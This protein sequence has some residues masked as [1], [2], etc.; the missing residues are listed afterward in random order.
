MFLLG[1]DRHCEERER[2]R[3]QSIVPTPRYGLLARNDG[4]PFGRTASIRPNLF[5]SATAMRSRLK[6][7][8]DSGTKR[9]RI[10]DSPRDPLRSPQHLALTASGDTRSSLQGLD[11][12]SCQGGILKKRENAESN[13]K[14]SGV[15][16]DSRWLYLISPL[17]RYLPL[18]LWER[19][20]RM[21][22]AHSRRARG[23]LHKH[24]PRGDR[25]LIRRGLRSRHLL[26]QGEKEE[27]APCFS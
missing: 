4:S 25:P 6:L 24:R 2:R 17:A 13:Q 5:Q 10:A 11:K 12:R 1:A 15:K 21:S 19:V 27:R 7:W 26:P 3:K 18:P 20:D 9:A 23:S 14:W 8:N 22:E 16:D